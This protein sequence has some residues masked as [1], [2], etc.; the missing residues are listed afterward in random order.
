VE[1]TTAGTRPL[2]LLNGVGAPL[3]TWEPLRERLSHRTTVAVDVPG[4]GGSPVSWFPT[5]IPGLARTVAALLDDLEIAH[6]DVLGY[7]FGGAVAQEVARRTPS[8]V[9]ALVL[10]ATNCGLGAVPG[11]PAAL[12]AL[13]A[14]LP[15]HLLPPG[16]GSL[17]ALSG[18]RGT[19]AD[20]SRAD[21]AWAARPPNPL[22]VWWQAWAIGTWTSATWLPRIAAPTL[23]LT[24]AD[25][26]VVPAANARMLARCLPNATL[27]EVPHAGHFA[28]LADDPGPSGDAVEAFLR[29]QA[30]VQKAVEAPAEGPGLAAT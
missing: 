10:A 2:L 1:S 28:L 29:A 9:G 21:A 17:L 19:R 6:A 26:R 12:A 14:P 23:V 20:F 24:G 15:V 22:G 3:E 11:D 27:C 25:D 5:T 13:I 8:R 16:R 18:D 30:P 7:S 4:T